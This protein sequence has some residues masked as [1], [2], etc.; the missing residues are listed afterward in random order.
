[1]PAGEAAGEGE[2]GGAGTVDGVASSAVASSA[3]EDSTSGLWGA[4]RLLGGGRGSCL[5]WGRVLR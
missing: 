3:P 1:V 4:Q 5:R 2:G